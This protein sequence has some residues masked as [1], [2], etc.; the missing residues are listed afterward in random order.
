MKQKKITRKEYETIGRNSCED[1]AKPLCN[2]VLT[3][4]AGGNYEILIYMKWILFLAMFIPVHLI[5]VF[6]LMWDGGLR[7]FRF[8]D[9]CLGKDF[10]PYHSDSW[11]KASEIM[12]ERK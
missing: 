12:K 2:F 1:W 9:R 7:E 5:E 6:R 4:T 11:E 10:L 3:E 8:G